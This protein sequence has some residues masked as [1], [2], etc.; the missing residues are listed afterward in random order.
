MAKKPN[1]SLRAIPR[2]P[3]DL[4][5]FMKDNV[6]KPS[7]EAARALAAVPDDSPPP[8]EPVSP[9]DL[10]PNPARSLTRSFRGDDGAYEVNGPRFA[11]QMTRTFGPEASS[12]APCVHT[13]PAAPY[14][15]ASVTTAQNRPR[16]SDRANS[17]PVVD[18]DALNPWQAK[19]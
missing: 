15:P 13:S 6:R 2:P 8:A 7:P 9:A 10:L 5:R 16:R 18:P 12:P 11:P 4:N 14:T 17:A 1:G 19:S 3:D